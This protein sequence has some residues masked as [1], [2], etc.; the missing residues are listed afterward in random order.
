L[1]NLRCFNGRTAPPAFETFLIA[2]AAILEVQSLLAAD[3]RQKAAGGGGSDHSLVRPT[4]LAFFL[5]TA[6]IARGA[7]A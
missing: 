5:I 1:S 6:F 4:L 2:L 7:L 3:T